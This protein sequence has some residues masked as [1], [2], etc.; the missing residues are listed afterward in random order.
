MSCV[1]FLRKLG[2]WPAR[3]ATDDEIVNAETENAQ[4]DNLTAFDEMRKAYGKVPESNNRLR[5][6]IRQ[7][8]TPFADLERMMHGS[9]GA[10]RMRH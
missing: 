10:K 9:T 1:S 2:L 4:R 7:S 8:A 5:E 3:Q 6:T